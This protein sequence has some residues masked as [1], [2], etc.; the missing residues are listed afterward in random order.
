MS[1]ADLHNLLPAPRVTMPAEPDRRRAAGHTR[2]RSATEPLVILAACA[3]NHRLGRILT[4]MGVK[5]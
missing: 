4:P 1:S 5:G 2:E 3:V